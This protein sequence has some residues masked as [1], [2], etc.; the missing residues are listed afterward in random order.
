VN[1]NQHEEIVIVGAGLVG[2]LLA[3]FL[4]RR[5]LPVVVHEQR[6]EIRFA[7]RTAGRSINLVVTSRGVDALRAVE[8]WDAVRRLCVP[9]RGRMMHAID[10]GLSYQ[11]YGRDDSECNFSISRLELNRFLVDRAAAH[12]VRFHFESALV[13][14][15]P[16]SNR[17]AFGREADR[18][19]IRATLVIGADGAGSALRRGMSERPGFVQSIEPLGHSYKELFIP[20]APDG[21]YRI[22]GNAL[23]IWPRGR[24]MLMALPN[25]DGS[26]TVTLYLPDGSRGFA[27]L[28]NESSVLA[29]FRRDFADAIPLIPDLVPSFLSNPTGSL[30]TI[31]CSPWQ[32]DGRAVLIGDAAHAIVPFF[33]QG[34]NCGFEDCVVFD[35]LIGETG[36]DWRAVLERFDRERKP[37]AEAIADMALENFVEM[38]ERV[39]EPEFLLRKR[40][41]LRLEKALPGEYRSR[42][43]MVAYSNIPYEIA[44]RAGLIQR[45]ILDELCRDL[46]SDAD[47]DL[48]RA[49]SLIR[50]RLAPYLGNAGVRLDF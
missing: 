50:D 21:G 9:V 20:A 7:D 12:G 3:I 18:T 32:V 42:Y 47:L 45:E 11:P 28:T 4:A 16:E 26:F 41:E 34:M 31:R 17:L 1:A 13:A 33:G 23:H 25:A 19:E 10:G 37:S 48:D 8:L 44:Q 22:E 36:A 35:R 24:R 6:P 30:A 46:E 14:I 43:S 5:G 27:D 2:S 29:L 38:S 15:A 39:G 49:R 40:V